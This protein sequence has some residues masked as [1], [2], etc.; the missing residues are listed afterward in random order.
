MDSASNGAE[1][2]LTAVPTE[3]IAAT[4]PAPTET[5][6]TQTVEP[7][8]PQV[9]TEE[10]C[11]VQETETAAEVAD[12]T[13][14][15]E[16][17]EPIPD[18]GAQEGDLGLVAGQGITFRLFNYST[19]INKAPGN[20]SWRPIS[21]YFVFRNSKM[22]TGTD[23]QAVNIP[24][25]SINEAHDQDGFTKNHATVERV[26]DGGYPVLDLTRNADG[27]ERTDPGISKSTRSLAYLFSAGDHAVTA[28]TPR[29]TVLRQNGSHYWYNSASHAVDYDVGES[30]FRLRSYTERNS[31]TAGY[32]SAYGDFLPFTYTCGIELGA[33]E[34]GIPYHV[35]AEDTDYWFGMTMNVNF[36]QTKGGKLGDQNMI[37]SFSGDDDVWVFVDD[38]LVLDLGGTH[39]T[40]DGSINFATGQVRQYLSWVGANSTEDARTKGSET[41]FPTTIR[42]CFDAAGRTP[43]G[44]WNADGT[45]F[46]D[47]TE[48][49]LN[50]FYLERGSAVA[51]CS[52]DFHLPTLPDESLTV[53]KD[54]S[55]DSDAA[56]RDYIADSLSYKSRVMKADCDGNPT[57]EHFITAGMTYDL[58]ENGSKIGTGTVGQDGC[59]ALKAGQSAQFTQML[60]K[61]NGATAYVVEEIMPSELVGQYGGVE[62]IVSGTGGDTVTEEN[63]AESFT[64][65]RTG[66]LSAE[67]TQTVTFRNRVD[68]SR[69]GTLSVTKQAAPGTVIPEEAQFRIQVS[70]GGILL[71]VGTHYMV[72][73]VRRTVETAGILLLHTG[74]TAVLEQGILSGT[75]YEITEPNGTAEGY[76]PSYTGIVEPAGEM[77]CTQDGVSGT[78]PLE[79]TVHVTV[80]NADYDFSVQIPFSKTVLDYQK[81]GTFHFLVEQVEKAEG[82]WHVVDTLPGTRIT[83]TNSQATAGSI[84]I[85]Y[86]SNVEGVFYYRISER[87]SSGDYIYDSNFYIVE[88]TVAGGSANI[89]GIQKNG[90][91]IV[92]SISFINRAV[93]AL[94]VTKTVTGG[95]GSMKF[96]FSATVLLHGEPF[97]MPSPASGAGYAVDGNVISFSLAHGESIT[98]PSIPIGATVTVEELSYD[99][100]LV[101]NR[102]EG[103]DEEISS[104][105]K[106]I[107]FSNLDR[108]LHFRNQSGFRLPNTGGSGSV[109]YTAGGATLSSGVGAALL[110][111]QSRKERR[112]RKPPQA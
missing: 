67:Q 85:G 70:L 107:A 92:E 56:V 3:T 21:D 30:R 65:F 90:T 77:E 59:F 27:S 48:H 75:V 25:P 41:S 96:P 89:T 72:D 112:K 49:T 76:R 40:V 7:S 44:G 63:P 22:E 68:T 66:V 53:T 50:F 34:D 16:P 88:V 20:G 37:F 104:A 26:L 19:D 110:Y 95:I 36:F 54:L 61:G 93:V 43:K 5:K 73:N 4:M 9:T 57:Q 106:E 98:I 78:V 69:L 1:V 64:A 10:T 101:F 102:L 103:T 82:T 94:T 31:T 39:G 45:T 38:V 33:T 47:F 12:E 60:Y 8:V 6:Q 35:M 14:A 29:N 100:F 86:H 17:T 111:R 23:P 15:T 80:T 24:Q 18:A 109:L 74:E 42:A 84:T 11:N 55:A 105:C 108:T 46:A 58:L 97:V 71:P 99:G 13:S 87:R 91:E 52:L 2:D 51:N 79:G 32:G 28:Y 62:Y 81:S 83:V